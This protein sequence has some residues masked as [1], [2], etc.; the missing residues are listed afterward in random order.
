MKHFLLMLPIAFA[1]SACASSEV[2]PVSKNQ[3]I[4]STSAAPACGTAGAA[5]VAAKMAA[6][7]TIRRG[8]ERYIILGSQQANNVGVI[9]TGP[10]YAN[11]Y[12][13]ASVYGNTAYGSSTTYYGGQ[14]TIFTGSHDRGLA[15]LMLNRGDKG[16][17][18]G[19][20]AKA[21]LGEDWQ[22]LV[23]NGINTCT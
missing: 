22:Q 20:D 13:Q 15:V 17:A 10:T 21:Q 1:I 6:I 11:T 7:E 3:I 23:A 9:R 12:G 5:K 2:I 8:F 4:I 18:N 16:F 19:V 14:Q